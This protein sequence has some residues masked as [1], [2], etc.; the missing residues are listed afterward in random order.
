MASNGLRHRLAAILAADVVGY[1]R[2]MADDDRATVIALDAARA[3]FRTEIEA[4]QGRVIDMAGDSVLAAFETASGAVEAAL[5]VQRA[6]GATLEGV[7]E[8]RRMRFRIG[9]HLGDVIEKTDGTVYGDGVNIAARLESLAEPG[10][11]AISDAVHGA[12]RN[13]VGAAFADAGEHSV[14][15]IPRPV[16]VWR[17]LVDAHPNEARARADLQFGPRDRPSLAVLPFATVGDDPEGV[18]FA[19]GLVEDLII[20]LSRISGLTVIARNSSFAYKGRSVDVRQ[21]ARELGVRYVLDG[22]VRKAGNRVRITA[23]LV[24]AQSGTQVWAERYDRAVDD[25]FA[26]QDQITLVLATEMQVR[27]TEGEQARLR[28]T[29]VDNVEAWNEWV[30]GLGHF[31]SGVN[32]DTLSAALKCWQRAVALDPR[33]ASLHAMLGLLHYLDARFGM[34]D[35][36]PTALAKAGVYVDSALRLDPGNADAHTSSSLLLLLQGRYDNAV[37]EARRAIECGPGSAD[38][39]SFAAFV[40]ANA[41]HPHEAV[42]Q[43]ERAMRLCPIYPAYYLGHLGLA[44]RLAGKRDSAIDAFEAYQK[45]SPG[46]G[47][48]DLVILSHQH[49]QPEKAREWAAKLLAADPNFTVRA[50]RATQ[51]RADAAAV[52]AEAAA[53]EAAGLPS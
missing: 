42:A 15:N 45:S 39:A 11:I 30:R 37:V 38:T 9:V 24:D 22:S 19:D 13:R 28:Y 12:V 52:D 1:S 40:L 3:V 25:I 5:A 43:M 29:T 17:A 47:V 16:R 35:D 6:L 10:S 51:F 50:W 32:R 27:L 8:H 49:G 53:L 18:P 34:W 21:I 2:L 41:G 26:V 4:R 36:R 31:H 44:Y 20:T 7:A 23:Q 14:K 33:S 46:R 48:S